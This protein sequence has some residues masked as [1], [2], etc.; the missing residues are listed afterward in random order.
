MS[1]TQRAEEMLAHVATQQQSGQGRSAYCEAQGINIH[2]LNYWAAKARRG[3]PAV[4]FASVEI[5][6]GNG[7]ELHYPNGVRLVL[8]V[9]TAL[10]EVAAC[11]RLY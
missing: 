1:R 6:S 11:I 3:T 4:G 8:P 2:T 7:I 5:T 10:R 9:G